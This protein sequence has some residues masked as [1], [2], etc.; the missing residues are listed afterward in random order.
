MATKFGVAGG[1][2]ERRVRP[3]WDAVDSRQYKPALKLASSL[4]V[5]YP[6]S[7]YAL[8]LKALIL[9][10][11]GKP[12]EALRVCL[13]AKEFLYSDNSLHID[14]LT[15]S[16]L[17]IVFQR[18]DHLDHA[19][20][21][22]E[23]ACAKH[24]NNLEI[25]IGLFN[26][27][28][29]ECS[30]V[31]QQQIAIK[32]YK[33]FS[34]ERFLLWAVCSI[35]LQVVCNSSGHKLLQLAEALLKKHMASHSLHEPDAL[36]M[37]I[38]I[39]EQQE[40]YDAALEVLSGNLGSLIGIEEDK[41]RIQG[42]LLARACNY[43][44]AAEI[45]QRVLESCPDDWQTFLHY[46]ACLLEED[47]N[48]SKT[49]S[50]HQSCLPCVDDIKA[51][52]A[53]HLTKDEFD[54]RI[55]NALSFVQKLQMDCCNDCVRGPHLAQ[56]EIERRHRLH[57]IEHDGKFMES[58]LNYFYRFGHLSCFTSDVEMFL[59]LLTDDE[60]DQLLDNMR[61][62]ESTSASPIKAL[63]H[64]MTVFK[65]QESFG[66]MFILS[67]RELEGT[68]RKML[69]MFCKDLKLSRDLDPQENMHG[70][71]LLSMASNILVLLFWRT[72]KLGYLLEAIMVLEY[73]LNIRR[74][75]WQ[76]KILLLHLYSYLGALP[77]AYEW[78]STLDVKNI[79]LETV[80][81]HILPQMISSPLWQENG[82]LLKDYLKFMD[83]HLRE[84]ADLTC[85]AYRH[86]N[87]SK[88]IE[89][90]QFKDRLE[91]SNQL[92]M[93]RLDVSILQLKQKADSLQEVECIFENLNYGSRFLEMSN[94][95]KLKSLTFNED[96]QARPWWSPT[97][98]VNLLSGCFEEG[99]ACLRES[100]K[101]GDEEYIVKKVIERKSILPRLVYLSIQSG[102]ISL[103]ENDRNGSLSD[104]SA[105]GEL[106]C[107][108]ER[109]ARNI[110][111]SFD[112]AISVILAISR[113]QKSFKEFGSDFIS[114]INFA[115]FVNAWNLCCRGVK[116]L[117]EDKCGM[118]S[119][120]IVDNLV[121]S[122]V[123]EQLM[124]AEPILASPGD[125]LSILVQL[126]TEPISWHI[127]VIQSRIR[128][129]LPS[130]RRKKRSGMTD[131]LSS[132]D[133]Q[134]VCGSVLCLI[135]A[136]Q[137]I[138]RWVADQMN[139][140]EDQDLDILLSHVH[141]GDA[142]GGPGCV[143]QSLEQ[144]AC[145]DDVGDRILGALQ[146]WSCATVCRKIVGAQRKMLSHLLR[147]CQSKLKLLRS[148]Q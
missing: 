5:K 14:E 109:Y 72:R 48:W 50:S 77:L 58:L 46:L 111:L 117:N 118:S 40:K 52:K 91:N 60:K 45:F 146:S 90:V 103:K 67:L 102:S 131:H 26:C 62:L 11:M 92:L 6:S 9:E 120:R 23:H 59:R 69:E 88:V 42:R 36:V 63:G 24:P 121:K 138:E 106:K 7:P 76:Y 140:S 124:H 113:G 3:I 137:H 37:Y 143:L 98:S 57:G 56:I 18:L 47:V 80:S 54:S 1:I 21:C 81:H 53:T 4:L 49:N 84:A 33:H 65:V 22:Y 110:G 16:T 97:S 61:T 35:E 112:D 86:R 8:A 32:M 20:S 74:Y 133:M 107:L 147:I 136:I 105:V 116:L 93:A 96:L 12:D 119:W 83:D 2:P 10:R 101:G 73:G 13:E 135:D 38:S 122:C 95:D 51:C 94:E 75:V 126:V 19:S 44:A 70:E 25:M 89:F 100:L 82:D 66:F 114:W 15:L 108:L 134:A 87:Y 28:V 130:G 41:L 78:Y 125:K 115:V 31:K 34:E 27:Y 141:R 104:A 55:S 71:D 128:W 127:L 99:S 43:A 17:Q 129:M 68:A 139:R 85:V 145:A 142:E 148:M 30:F 29:R 79:L 132:P 39:L 64:A 123:A 144:N